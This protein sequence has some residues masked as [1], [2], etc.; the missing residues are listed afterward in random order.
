MCLQIANTDSYNSLELLNWEYRIAGSISC[1]CLY[2]L[3]AEM[4]VEKRID[5]TPD[6]W[7]STMRL[8]C[9]QFVLGRIIKPKVDKH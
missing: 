3:A 2:F 6:W 5:Q 9:V 4:N 7:G 1:G 8:T